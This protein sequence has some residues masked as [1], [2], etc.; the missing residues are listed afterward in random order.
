VNLRPLRR[1]GARAKLH[2]FPL[3]RNER[4]TPGRRGHARDVRE[5]VETAAKRRSDEDAVGSDRD[6]RRERVQGEEHHGHHDDRELE[7]PGEEHVRLIPEGAEDAVQDGL[8]SLAREEPLPDAKV[9][10]RARRIEPESLEE[11]RPLRLVADRE[12]DTLEGSPADQADLRRGGLAGSRGLKVPGLDPRTGEEESAI[13]REPSL[14][15]ANAGPHP[16]LA[17]TED[18]GRSQRQE[19]RENCR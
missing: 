11:A 9:R 7:G 14:V 2:L 5:R 19:A 16:L 18:R 4:D 15:G 6:A 13:D 17:R 8:R 1:A 12:G 10:D 3:L